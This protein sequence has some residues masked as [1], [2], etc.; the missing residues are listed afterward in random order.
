[1]RAAAGRL[2]TGAMTG[3]LLVFVLAVAIW[4]P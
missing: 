4:M 2:L 3:G 1:M